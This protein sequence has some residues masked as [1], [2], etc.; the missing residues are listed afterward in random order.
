MAISHNK[1]QYETI[2]LATGIFSQRG[3]LLC[4]S[5][6][7]LD[8]FIR[9]LHG[10]I[11][12]QQTRAR[13][14]RGGRNL[15]FISVGDPTYQNP[16]VQAR[17]IGRIPRQLANPL[18]QPHEVLLHRL[19]EERAQCLVEDGRAN[20]PVVDCHVNTPQRNE[21]LLDIQEEPQA[22][23]E[24]VVEEEQPAINE[25]NLDEVPG[26]MEEEAIAD[27]EQQED[28]VEQQ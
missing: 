2:L 25:G 3:N 19:C 4:I 9:S 6:A 28:G 1:F 12:L 15:Y 10:T 27:N 21:G 17:N 20:L 7:H 14:R 22:A 24:E 11:S 5:R 8:Y 23:V 16:V 18:E 26:L 13:V